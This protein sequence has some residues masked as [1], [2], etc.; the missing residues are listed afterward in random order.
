MVTVLYV[1]SDHLG[2]HSFVGFQESFNVDKFC[3]IC[4]ASRSDIQR[5]P[6]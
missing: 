4:L 5:V 1:L 2:A 6:V 3:R